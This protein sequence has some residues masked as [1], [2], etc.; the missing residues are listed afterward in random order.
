[1]CGGVMDGVSSF[2]PNVLDRLHYRPP[3]RSHCPRGHRLHR[4]CGTYTAYQGRS[5]H[6]GHR[7]TGYMHC[8]RRSGHHTIHHH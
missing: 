7:Q 6:Y 2:R 4:S 8:D 5:H 1:M 3:N